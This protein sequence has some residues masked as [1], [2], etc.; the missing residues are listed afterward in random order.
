MASAHVLDNPV[1]ESLCAEQA[2]LALG[3]ASAKRYPKEFGPFAAIER[4]GP[5]GYAELEGLV[6]HEELVYLAATE[7]PHSDAWELIEDMSMLQMVCKGRVDEHEGAAII[8][9]T[10]GDLPE[11]LG[12]IGSVYPE[13]FRDRTHELGTYLG[14][15]RNGRLVAMAGERMWCR[16][17]REISGVCTHPDFTGHGFARRLI[18][19]LVNDIFAQ[20]ITPFLHVSHANERAQ[21]IYRALRFESRASIRLVAIRRI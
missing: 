20:G 8:P 9:L 18:A 3:G 12:L 1:W 15:R 5:D 19:Q 4:S 16:G 14:I 21:S 2:S 17:Y 10:E 6:S 7:P 11:M 13:F